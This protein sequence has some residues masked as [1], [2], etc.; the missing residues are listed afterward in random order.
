METVQMFFDKKS[1]LF[2]IK[3]LRMNSIRLFPESNCGYPACADLHHPGRSACGLTLHAYNGA[4]WC[5]PACPRR[6]LNGKH[7]PVPV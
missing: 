5:P 1:N 2:Y 4:F 6:Q 3:A 7:A